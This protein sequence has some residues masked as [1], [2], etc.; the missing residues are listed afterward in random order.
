MTDSTEE[1]TVSRSDGD[2]ARAP[3]ERQRHEESPDRSTE[4]LLA[5]TGRLLAESGVGDGNPGVGDG[6][7]GT[8]GGV[9]EGTRVGPGSDTE[10]ESSSST[11]DASSTSWVGRLW[12]SNDASER[13]DE[14]AMSGEGRSLSGYF[15][16]K[17]FLAIILLFG[18]GFAV[19][20][21]T[22]PLLPGGPIGLF[23]AAFVLGLATARRRYLETTLG[24]LAV[25]AGGF[26]ASNLAGSLVGA[27]EALA[28]I[29]GAVG[30]LATLLGYY[31]ARDLKDGLTREM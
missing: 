11:D 6:N 12:G 15:S 16:P 8:D 31:F 30:L 25:G 17:A 3:G 7:S 19:A 4:D 5:E 28:L 22:V 24:G 1:R 13:G 2:D 26:L 20:Q 29:G 10:T 23:A 9:S 14:S 21:A 18:L 27:G